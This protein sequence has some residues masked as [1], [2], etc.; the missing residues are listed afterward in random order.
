LVGLDA[1]LVGL[2]ALLVGLEDL[3]VG[4][5][6]RHEDLRGKFLLHVRIL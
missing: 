1:L 6:H 5:D 4:K 3:L 2:D